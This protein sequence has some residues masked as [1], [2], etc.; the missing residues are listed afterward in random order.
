[1]EI[2]ITKQRLKPQIIDMIKKEKGLKLR[3]CILLEKSTD[4]INRYLN[5][6]HEI[7]TSINTLN[8]IS[9]FYNTPLNELIESYE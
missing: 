8:L 4:T 7:L 5:E 9:K 6:S 1:M 2:T 3:L